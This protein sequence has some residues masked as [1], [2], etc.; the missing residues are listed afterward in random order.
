VAEALRLYPQP[1]VLIRRSEHDLT[2]PQGTSDFPEGFELKKGCDIFLSTWNLHRSPH[3]WDEPNEFDPARF[4]RRFRNP[5]VAGWQGYNPKAQGTS[6]YPNEVRQRVR[7]G[8]CTL[9]MQIRSV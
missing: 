6:M 5:E 4:T 9:L 2:L 7:S 3:L 1:P 8:C